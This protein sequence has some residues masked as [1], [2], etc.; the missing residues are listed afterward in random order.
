MKS[1]V[2][3]LKE[4]SKTYNE[5]RV[6]NNV[7]FSLNSGEIHA[8]IGENGAGKS[9]LMNI[10]AGF[11]KMDAGEILINGQSVSS[12]SPFQAQSQGIRMIFQDIQLVPSLNV[13][14]NIFLGNW[15]YYNTKYLKV[16]NKEKQYE[17]TR[18]LLEFLNFNINPHLKISSLDAGQQKMVEI[19][20]AV[21]WNSKILILDEVT[22]YF[23]DLEVINLFKILKKVKNMGH[24][25]VFISHRI[26][27][28]LKIADRVTILREGEIVQT[29]TISN[30][31][32]KSAVLKMSSN[33]FINR[34]P[35]IKPRIG[36]EALRLENVSNNR[37]DHINF[38]LRRGE[39]IG[40]T[41][42]I[43]SGRTAVAEAIFG[44]NPALSGE[45]YIKRKLASI[46]SPYDAIN[47]KIGYL[48]ED[49]KDSLVYEFGIAKN[50]SL[51]NI[52]SVITNRTI[53][54][55]L[56]ERIAVDYANRLGFTGNDVFKKVKFLSGGT[57][58]KVMIAKWL[59][60]R[61]DVFI[62]NEPTKGLDIASKVEVYN[63]MN[64]LILH[65][66]AVLFISSDINELI[67]MCDRI[68]VIYRGRIV[69][70]LFGEEKTE[71]NIMYY[72]MG[73]V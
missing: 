16:I 46:K 18:K 6:L 38:S 63:L 30:F 61:A 41:G 33:Y 71:S 15:I 3:E 42:L 20:K 36:N 56:E 64:E 11:E 23:N 67:G 1:C 19:A 8:V 73:A 14:E 60:S 37:L 17:E 13:M 48:P 32:K 35:K 25:I 44:I 52:S 9:T 31:D 57:Q 55:K 43:G 22:A 2:L 27:E 47:H 66:S 28:V 62:F 21:Y 51:S 68:L 65:D 58:Q 12:N 72:A 53:D 26:N 34:Y 49:R 7:N 50:V 70:E 39:I 5:H 45:I 29:T 40:L 54:L 59:L 4:V 10:I 24:T 69:G